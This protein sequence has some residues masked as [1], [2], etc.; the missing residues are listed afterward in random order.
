VEPAWL[1]EALQTLT[2]TSEV[3]EYLL[4]RGT[5]EST[6]LAEGLVTWKPLKTAA[7]DPTFRSQYGEHGEKLD[8]MLV[9]PVRSP[10]GV[11]LGFEARNI[12]QKRILDYRLAA[13]K[14]LPFFI[15]TRRAMS[16][17]WAGADIWIVEG[18]FDLTAL[19]WGIPPGHVV[20]ATV[21]ANLTRQQL[22]FLRR[23]CKGR[24]HMAYDMDPTGRKA[25][26][27]WDDDQKKHHPGAIELLERVGL[28]CSNE[29]Y[30]GG[31]DPGEIWDHGGEAAI[32]A[33]FANRR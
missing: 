10:R 12:Y 15:G 28:P 23:F 32:R 17:I 4:G 9:I 26:E 6:I 30:D 14:Y 5:R 1:S 7:P 8:G 33:T 22:E 16:A 31:K 19:E 21:R 2:L 27:G 11:L 13:A 18:F 20:L 24:V 29:K 3:E 25:V